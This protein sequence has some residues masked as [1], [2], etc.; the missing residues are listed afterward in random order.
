[1]DEQPGC[2]LNLDK[3]KL[4]QIKEDNFRIINLINEFETRVKEVILYEYDIIEK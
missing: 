1:M 3:Y 4:K 2:I